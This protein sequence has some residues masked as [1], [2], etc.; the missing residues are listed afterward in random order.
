MLPNVRNATPLSTLSEGSVPL[1]KRRRIETPAKSEPGNDMHLSTPPSQGYSVDKVPKPESAQLQNPHQAVSSGFVRPADDER[2]KQD[3]ALECACF[4]PVLEGQLTSN[5]VVSNMPITVECGNDLST[6]YYIPVGILCGQS[7]LQLDVFWQAE[8][9]RARYAQVKALRK[10]VKQFYPLLELHKIQRTDR[11]REKALALI[12]ECMTNFPLPETQVPIAQRLAEATDTVFKTNDLWIKPPARSRLQ[13]LQDQ[14]TYTVLERLHLHLHR[15]KAAEKKDASK[16]PVKAAAQHRILLPSEDPA[17]VHALVEW[18]YQSDAPPPF[19]SVTHLCAIHSLADKLGI[20]RLAADCMALLTS[21]A[22][23][24]LHR[25]KTEAVTLK[26]L[27]DVC[28]RGDAHPDADADADADPLSSPRVVGEVFKVTLQTPNP[29]PALQHLVADA[30]ASS[31]DDALLHQLLPAMNFDMR[32]KV[33]VAMLANM[34]AQ[35]DGGGAAGAGAG[36]GAERDGACG[37]AGRKA[38]IKS[39]RS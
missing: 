27:L 16:N 34:K 9:L 25:A 33:T 32:G 38:C 4:V 23:R 15:S 2:S 5:S 19:T 22:A 17:T 30:I 3:F 6:R 13:Q 21:A 12:V 18:L 20:A 39:E 26:D 14:A 35:G 36:A 8:D 11:C 28:T 37:G 1:G 24:I 10:R 31:A 29:P 7:Q